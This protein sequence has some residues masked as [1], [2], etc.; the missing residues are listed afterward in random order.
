ML[1]AAE[2]DLDVRWVHGSEA[3]KYNTDPDIQVHACDERTY[4]LRQNKAVRYE[5]PCRDDDQAGRGLPGRL[6]LPAR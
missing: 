5:A 1:E 3:A 2:L 4:I 6:E